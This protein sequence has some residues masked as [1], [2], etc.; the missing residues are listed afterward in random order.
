M[1]Y[2]APHGIGVDLA[3]VV[4]A[5]AAVDVAD[6]KSPRVQVAVHHRQSGVVGEDAVVHG[7]D[8]FVVGFDPGHLGCISG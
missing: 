1:T 7:Q 2:L 8:P 5:V 4:A 3:H 6:V